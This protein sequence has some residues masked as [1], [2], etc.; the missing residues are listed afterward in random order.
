MAVFRSVPSEARGGG[1]RHSAQPCH[2]LVV[3]EFCSCLRLLTPDPNDATLHQPGRM[4]QSDLRDLCEG[5][6]RGVTAQVTPEGGSELGSVPRT[7]LMTFGQPLPLRL[8]WE[9]QSAPFI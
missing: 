4:S 6:L 9:W 3:H 2:L 7:P 8:I 1:H 5:G